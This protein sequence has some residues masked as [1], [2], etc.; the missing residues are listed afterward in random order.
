[1]RSISASPFCIISSSM[2]ASQGFDTPIQAAH[3]T[4]QVVGPPASLSSQGLKVKPAR[5]TTQLRVKNQQFTGVNAG[6]NFT[7]NP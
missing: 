3:S 2:I 4:Q 6:H 7:L 1:M 5:P